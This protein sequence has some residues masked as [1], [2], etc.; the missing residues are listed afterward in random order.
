MELRV[1]VEAPGVA[2]IDLLV[3][4]NSEAR[5]GELTGALSEQLGVAARSLRIRRTGLIL[6]P[7]LPL[8]D[9]D[10]RDGDRLE[11][12]GG[13]E[14]TLADTVA[15]D[16]V[17]ELLVTGGPEAGRRL[18][19]TAGRHVV[20]RGPGAD[21][22]VPDP[23]MSR[24]HL[25]FD[26]ARDEIQV[27]D[28]GSSNGTFLEGRELAE[29]LPLLDGQ[30]VEAGRSTF[31]LGGLGA[32][33]AATGMPAAG[34]RIAFN[35]PPRVGGS[36][37]AGDHVV[38]LPPVQDDAIH[39]PIGALLV[40]LA[41]GGILIAVTG[42]LLLLSFALL[43]PAMALVNF[44]DRRRT[45]V[46]RHGRA[47]RE[48]RAQ[49]T[50]LA[51]ALVTA[52]ADELKA[53][54]AAAP[55]LVALRQRV[56]RLDPRLWERRPG[57]ADALELRV[58]TADLPSSIHAEVSGAGYA[59]LRAEAE[60][61]LTASE[62]LHGVPVTARLQATVLGLCGPAAVV[63]SLARSLILQAAALHSPYDLRIACA[64]TA[65]QPWDW[66]GWL[67]HAGRGSVAQ[68]A[69]AGRTLLERI[70]RDDDPTLVVMDG[71]LRIEPSLAAAAAAAGGAVIWLDTAVSRLPG[72]A[73]LIAE[74]DTAVARLRLTDVT[75]GAEIADVSADGVG[76]EAAEEIARL[77][78]PLDDAG[79]DSGGEIPRR[80]SLL[81]LLELDDPDPAAIG[82][83]WSLSVDHLRAPVGMGPSGP[84]EI[85]A[86]A[87]EGLRLLLGGMPGSGKS[88]LLQTLIVSLAA[89][90]PP[91][92]LAFL[93]IDYKGG[94]AFRDCI[95]L[96]HV[97]GLV[98]DLD[99]H[100]AERARASL[101]AELRH[102]EQ[103]LHRA[104]VRSLRE[105]AAR[106]G[107]DVPPALLIVID[108]FAALVREVPSFVET[109]V[110]VAQRGR[111]LGLHLVLATQRPRGVVSD[112]LRANANLRIAMRMSDR[113][114]STDI[115]EVGDAAA[116]PAD[117]PGRALALT[118]RLVDGSPELTP[119]QA[120]YVSGLTAAVDAARVRVTP[121]RRAAA[122]GSRAAVLSGAGGEHASDLHRLVSACAEAAA[123]ARMARPRPPWLEPLPDHLALDDV[124]EPGSGVVL[125]LLDE[126]DALRQTPFAF[127]PEVDGSMLIYG[128]SGAG[129]TTALQTV[130]LSLARGGSPADVQ[131]YG[132]DFASGALRA[133]EALPHCGS[134]VCAGEDER[135][136]RLL[137]RLDDE[138]IRRKA[139]ATCEPRIV[140][141]VDGLAGF[142][143]TFERVDY[144]EPVSALVR[145]AAEG[146]ALG[147]HVV[148]TA[149]RRAEV[150][151]ALGGVVQL[152][153][154]LRLADPGE[155]ASLG[156]PRRA[157]AG[158]Q[159]PPGRG[160]VGDGLE[161]QVAAP[162]DLDAAGRELARRT[163]LKAPA[164][165]VLAEKYLRDRLPAPDA[166]LEAVIG[167]DDASLK[168]AVLRLAD[169]GALVAGGARTGKTTALAT[170]VAS[171]AGGPGALPLHLI[172]LRREALAELSVW[173]SLAIGVDE[174]A[175]RLATIVATSEPAIIVID[176]A[177][178]FSEGL[179]AASCA[180]LLNRGRDEPVR[181]I[182]AAETRALGGVFGGWLRDLRGEGRGLLLSPNLDVDGDLL[183]VRLPRTSRSRGPFPAGR[184]FLVARG[185]AA[186]VQ[187]AGD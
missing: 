4:A 129:K 151:S 173:S 136:I 103:A 58:G 67:P 109:L 181:I 26:V 13:H 94:A 180:A 157:L 7:E 40:P 22:V 144:G 171:L 42:N 14:G 30:I 124:W 37:P 159:L 24:R 139:A 63:E 138:L 39:L 6:A 101:R 11:L 16:T 2:A 105:L 134:V 93:L 162:G 128:A 75:D 140:V 102:R 31:T 80:V 18:P 74:L 170:I 158:A 82:R 78:A 66:V 59:D 96:P 135:I 92:R 167:I 176:D 127:T 21:I 87:V 108:E 164:V 155:Y 34:G 84:Y 160:F 12:L 86:G 81:D 142:T 3:E 43:A 29:P 154:V 145:L 131:L 46:G 88:E 137:S 41:I 50:T 23:S 146:R 122:P 47:V 179:A 91:D 147:I 90:H 117:L 143:G 169:G 68:G 172:A 65:S 51:D 95:D 17:A 177:V 77:L 100:L 72:S 150:P 48:F 70:A 89:T 165:G 156:V 57:D 99:E 153:V 33:T 49:V 44:L 64:V 163:R 126:P 185:I 111:S 69:S 148:A 118:G 55:D 98:T 130:G 8:A 175:E 119:F 71:A 104:G 107:P 53:R 112:G 106:G 73:G 187:V 10:L 5:A 97:A 76:R 15:R 186:L 168:P 178:S 20:G 19:L 152:R 61:L 45:S 27:G 79:G 52:R 56:E 120:A 125:G 38:T 32:P 60:Q 161:L 115:L 166:R 121:L 141:L 132:L 116:I 133:L 183:G 149:Q 35:R 83:R 9:A 62:T 54:R 85:D 174:G 110:D 28:A 113:A 36:L 184:G 123:D 1:T 114:E 25:V 182:A